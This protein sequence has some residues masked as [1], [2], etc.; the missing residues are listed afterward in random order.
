M[1]ID[2]TLLGQFVVL[3]VCAL[4][5]YAVAKRRG[6]P[7]LNRCAWA[8]VGLIPG[9]NLVAFVLLLV[10]PRYSTGESVS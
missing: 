8:A 3:A 2:L 5:L 9:V 1:D 10:L 6:H 4:I 7:F